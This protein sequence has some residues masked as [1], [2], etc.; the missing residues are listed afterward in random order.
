MQELLDFAAKR[1]WKRP[2]MDSDTKL[3][4]FQDRMVSPEPLGADC[5]RLVEVSVGRQHGLNEPLTVELQYLFGVGRDRISLRAED[6]DGLALAN[7]TPS[8][9]NNKL[10]LIFRKGLLAPTVGRRFRIEVSG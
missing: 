1:A 8:C 4:T 5:E 3:K 6:E 9:R 7:Q 10:P 2:V